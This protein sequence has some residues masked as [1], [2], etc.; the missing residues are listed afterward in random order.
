MKIA[1]SSSLGAGEG[2]LRDPL[3]KQIPDGHIRHLAHLEVLL[4]N[5]AASIADTTF[6]GFDKGVAGTIVGANV[7]VDTGPS[8]VAFT[9]RPIA[10][11]SILTARKRAAYC[12]RGV[13]IQC[14]ASGGEAMKYIH[15]S[16]QLSPPKPSG[17]SHLPLYLLHSANWPHE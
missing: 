15:G 17:Q 3:L 2:N 11:W 14:W 5:F 7:A 9:S 6:P 12:Y 16:R 10:K 4:D 1:L 13:S 8:F